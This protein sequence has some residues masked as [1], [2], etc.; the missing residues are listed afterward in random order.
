MGFIEN[1]STESRDPSIFSMKKAGL[2]KWDPR[3]KFT[4]KLGHSREVI[5]GSSS[6][7]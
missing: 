3:K 7:D 4:A 1:L 2:E 5:H 6:R